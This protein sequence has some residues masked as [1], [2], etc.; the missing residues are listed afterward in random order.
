VFVVGETSFGWEDVALA[1]RALGDWARLEEEVR[2]GS[3]CARRLRDAGGRLAR[4]DLEE[5]SRAFRYARHLER[6]ADMEAWLDGW[7]LSAEAWMGF[8]RRVVLRK[9]SDLDETEVVRRYPVP[10][11]EVNRSAH[12]VGACSGHLERFA[13]RLAGRVAAARS[14]AERETRADAGAER[15]LAAHTGE[16]DLLGLTEEAAKEKAEALGRVEA[17]FAAFRDQACDEA[18][19]GRQIAVRHTDWIRIEGDCLEFPA[20]EAAR[21]AALCVRDDGEE[22]AD[23]AE[24]SHSPLRHLRFYL[25]EVGLALAGPFLSASPGQLVGPLDFGGEYRLYRVRDKVLPTAAD[26]EVRE[27]AEALLLGRAVD[28]EVAGRVRWVQKW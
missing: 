27:K 19:V 3:A 2:H 23:V 9:T 11:R 16:P 13:R 8:V 12:V 14:V 28:R 20:A 26:P 21:E 24:R 17:L 18:A 6:A 5:E 1:A 15:F 4:L 25:E 7:A 22:L 10:M